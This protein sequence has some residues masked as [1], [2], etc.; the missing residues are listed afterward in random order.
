MFRQDPG[1]GP[2]PRNSVVGTGTDGTLRSKI[3]F[4]DKDVV[5]FLVVTLTSSG[6]VETRQVGVYVVLHPP[7]SETVQVR[8]S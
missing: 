4:V 1:C 7:A 5:A 8:P 2:T 3:T 6:N